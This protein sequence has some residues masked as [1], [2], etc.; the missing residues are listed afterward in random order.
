MLKDLYTLWNKPP[1]PPRPHLH[2]RA[3]VSGLTDRFNQL[4]KEFVRQGKHQLVFL[5]DEVL[6]QDGIN[7]HEYAQ[8]NN[9]VAESLES[10]KGNRIN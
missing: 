2:H 6:R 5:L 10:E 4:F 9:M 7:R 1:P 3:T 8:L